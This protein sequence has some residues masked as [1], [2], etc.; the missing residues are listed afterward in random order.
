MPVTEKALTEARTFSLVLVLLANKPAVLVN[1]DVDQFAAAAATKF[2]YSVSG[3][4]QGVV[5]AAT[6]VAAGVKLGAS[7]AHDD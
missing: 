6:D 7:L 3:G 4:K 2:Y 1:Q 5:L